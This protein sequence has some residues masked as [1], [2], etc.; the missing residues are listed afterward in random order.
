VAG[1]S[2]NARRDR[3]IA[4]V[5]VFLLLYAT[6]RS[7]PR[8][9]EGGGTIGGEVTDADGRTPLPA[10]RVT[11]R[12]QPDAAPSIR[13]ASY[14]LAGAPAD[15]LAGPARGTLTDASGRYLFDGVPRGVYVLEFVA[16]A[17]AVRTVAGIRMD[18][19]SVLRVDSRLEPSPLERITVSGRRDEG[20]PGL[21]R[22]VLG[23]DALADPPA[24]LGDPFR[25]LAGRAGIA[26][27]NDFKSE[28][29][30][31]GG[32]AMETEVLLDGQP[33]PYAYHF[34][35]GAG[36]AGTLNGDLVDTVEVTTGGFSVE[37]GDA[38]AGLIDLSTRAARPGRVTGTAGIGS[39]MAH[40][41]LFG[42]AGD[43]SWIFSGRFSDLGLYDDRVAGDGADGVAFHD[44][45]GAARMPLA[46]GARLEV[47]LLEAG[48]DYRQGLGYSDHAA[49]SSASR[50]LRGRLELPFG[51]G[52][53]LTVQVAD[54]NL[55]VD[56]AVTGGE[57]FD[58]IQRRRDL[59]VSLL[60]V[61]G[62]EHR[63]KG[64]VG[65]ETVVG[66]MTGSVA[67]GYGLLPSDL[68]YRSDRTSAF[69]EDT[70]RPIGTV[71]LRYGARADRSSWTGE[72]ALSPRFSL[73]V[74]P[75]AGLKLRCGAGRFVQFPRQEQVFLAAGETL[76]MQVADHFIAGLEV[77]LKRGTRLVIEA[78]RKDL[79]DPIGE[80]T[81]RHVE[82]PEMLTRFDRGRTLGAELTLE[83]RVGSPWIWQAHYAYLEATQSKQGVVTPRNA[84]QRHSLGLSLGRRL[85]RGWE[86]GAVFRYASGLPYTPVRSWTDGVDY[87]EI[88]GDLNGSRLPAYGRLD[89]RVGRSILAAW[90]V[91]EFRL[92]LLNVLNRRNVRSIDLSFEPSAATFY[93]TTYYQSP[94]LPVLGV[95]AEF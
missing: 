27:E 1:D 29:R 59:S 82:L 88:L 9:V 39:M 43:G 33:L 57:A 21:S 75:G 91:L 66:G 61:L 45:F 55:S 18:A 48:N 52:S 49:M 67:S 30:V 25:A 54:S 14:S 17:R 23:R 47:A 35:G 16:E 93:E 11:L 32:D 40:A 10:V 28:V 5:I 36:S 8:A 95:S 81:N 19:G 2:R 46:S 31:R 83:R 3:A 60:R 4:C 86:S 37:Y 84:D 53:V 22:T 42:P 24:A 58:Q 64:G 15:P 72:S 78:Y 73:E 68:D 65:L 87:G 74:S 34:G 13:P 89:L 77:S 62:A 71:A 63:L 90:G 50:G 6:A 44:L 79:K 41:A 12:P 7:V 94:F 69:A 51:P 70:W 26:P 92:D 20:G 76:R 38:I 80:A 85:G 56:S